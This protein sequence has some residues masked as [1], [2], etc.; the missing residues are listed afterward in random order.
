M[1]VDVE[2]MLYGSPAIDLA[3]ATLYTSTTWDIDCGVALSRDAIAGF[4]RDYLRRIDATLAERLKPWLL[5]MRRLTWLRTTTWACRYRVETLYLGK[6]GDPTSPYVRHVTRR[7]AD[8][9]D[10]ATIAQVRTEWLG[11]NPLDLASIA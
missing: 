6:A 10:A 11:D 8:F 3:H 7:I 2:K 1:L 4:Y 5:P 9:L